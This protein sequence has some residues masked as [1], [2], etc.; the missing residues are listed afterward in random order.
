MA[1][2]YPSKERARRA[3]WRGAVSTS[4]AHANNPYANAWLNRLWDR[5]RERAVADRA[6]AIPKQYLPKERKAGPPKEV[7]GS[8]ADSR[9]HKGNRG[10]P[11]PILRRRRAAEQAPIQRPASPRRP[12][13]RIR[14]TPKWVATPTPSRTALGGA[15]TAGIV[16]TV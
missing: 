13:R 16:E 5:G 6:L 4:R 7:P 15:G 14:V 8:R 12:R 10:G 3:F 9:A 11:G 1:N 2:G